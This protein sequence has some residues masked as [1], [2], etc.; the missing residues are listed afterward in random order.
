MPRRKRQPSKTGFY[1]WINRGINHKK[2]FHRDKD[3]NKFLSLIGEP[4]F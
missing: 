4:K 1:H 3:F 2:I